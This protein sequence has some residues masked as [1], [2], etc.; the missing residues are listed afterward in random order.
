[1][2]AAIGNQKEMTHLLLEFRA[3]VQ[4]VDVKGYT[5][6]YLAAKYGNY[7]LLKI[8]LKEQEVDVN[9][10]SLVRDV[11]L[12]VQVSVGWVILAKV[13]HLKWSWHGYS[14]GI[15]LLFCVVSIDV[16]EHVWPLKSF[17]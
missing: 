1:M 9:H 2:L 14:L 16:F 12:A 11:V 17:V 7:E 15:Y 6:L 5:A 4:A 8:L 3:S 10:K 13:L